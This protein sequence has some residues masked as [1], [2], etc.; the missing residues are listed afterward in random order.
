[1]TREMC[2]G[3]LP[4]ETLAKIR[5]MLK[6]IDRADKA[7]RRKIIAA[8][9]E[10]LVKGISEEHYRQLCNEAFREHDTAIDKAL[11]EG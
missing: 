2:I 4:P 1:M 10:F 8:S 7:M 3:D 6:A 5:E 9:E 11:W